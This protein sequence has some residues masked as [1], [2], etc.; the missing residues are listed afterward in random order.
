M[1]PLED[2]SLNA[3]QPEMLVKDEQYTGF[4]CKLTFNYFCSL[5]AGELQN[6]FV[7]FRK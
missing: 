4:S 7:C 2:N 6:Y 1:S 5:F 3:E